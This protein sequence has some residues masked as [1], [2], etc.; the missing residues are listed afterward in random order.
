MCKNPTIKLILIL[1]LFSLQNEFLKY[2]LNFFIMTLLLQ[3]L[4]FIIIDVVVVIITSTISIMTH[5]DV[6]CYS[7]YKN[8]FSN[9][10]YFKLQ[11]IS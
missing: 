2:I 3:L 10:F 6:V 5:L 4:L 1:I 11:F 9:L 7:V 8:I